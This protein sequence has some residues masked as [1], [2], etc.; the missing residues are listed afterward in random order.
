MAER[1]ESAE[2]NAASIRKHG[3]DFEERRGFT[4]AVLAPVTGE[5]LG[6]VYFDPPRTPAFDVDVRS[7]V[8][9]ESAGL[10]KPLHDCVRAWLGDRWPWKAPDYA[11][12]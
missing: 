4:Y 7:W 1:V 2:E 6:C 5:Y 10:D 3:L 12:R 9:A 11:H 8:K